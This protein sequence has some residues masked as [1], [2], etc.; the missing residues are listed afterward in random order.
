MVSNLAFHVSEADL[1][2]RCAA[3]CTL[4]LTCPQELFST[5]GNV[6]RVTIKYDKRCGGR[7]DG[8]SSW[9]TD[10]PP[11]TTHHAHSGRSVGEADV[12]FAAAADA[13]RAKNQYQGAKLDGRQ[14]QLQVTAVGSPSSN[15]T[16][17]LSSGVRWVVDAGDGCA[18]W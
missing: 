7:Q 2:V 10:N 3:V 6:Q 17:T 18:T 11:S 5:V 14:M 1:R 15:G 16:T 8:M 12:V 4:V 9:W 13:E